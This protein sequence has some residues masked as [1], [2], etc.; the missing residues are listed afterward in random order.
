MARPWEGPY[1]V[2]KRIND[3]VYR[4]RNNSLSKPK[5]VHRNR[6]WKYQGFQTE[7]WSDTNGTSAQNGKGAGLESDDEMGVDEM[8]DGA[9]GESDATL[10]RSKRKRTPRVIFDL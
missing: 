2:V 1:T 7:L 3:L 4:I 10:R 5:V 8:N 6:L 9:P